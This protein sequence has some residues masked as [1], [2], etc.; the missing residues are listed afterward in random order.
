MS[1]HRDSYNGFVAPT[2]VTIQKYVGDAMEPFIT[3]DGRYLL[4][5]NSNDAVHTTLRY[6]TRVNDHAFTYGGEVTG[7]SDPISLTAVPTVDEHG[8]IYFISTRSYSKTLSTVYSAVFRAGTVTAVHLTPGVSA[9]RRGVVDFDVDVSFDGN[10]LYISQGTF[11]G[12]SVPDGS[13]LIAYARRGHTFVSDPATNRL[14]R[15]VNHLAPLV[16]AAA[17]SSDGLELFFTAKGSGNLPVIY[18]AA[19]R[20]LDEPFGEIQRVS[21]AV[22]DVEAPGLSRNGQLLYFHR[23]AGSH[24]AIY[25]ASR[26]TAG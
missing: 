10:E 8:A 11:T 9:P 2:Q 6:A 25:V 16:Y 22:G 20:R 17:I 1:V 14:L 13:R 21:A 26:Q 18:R 12:G 19:R 7:A 4:F 23:L 24:F 3:P 5:N 15:S